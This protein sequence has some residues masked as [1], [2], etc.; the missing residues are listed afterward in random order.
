MTLCHHIG[1][2]VEP[3]LEVLLLFAHDT[4][5][6]RRPPAIID[7]V[8]ARRRLRLDDVGSGGTPAEALLDTWMPDVIQDH[9][10][11]GHALRNSGPSRAL[12]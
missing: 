4:R 10:V 3:A 8:A 2:V 5:L 6:R 7:F 9:T 11:V 1:S 12:H